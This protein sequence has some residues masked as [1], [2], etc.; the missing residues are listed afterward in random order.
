P[1]CLAIDSECLRQPSWARC[2]LPQVCRHACK[3]AVLRHDLQP[4]RWP[5]R[6]DQHCRGDSPCTND[7]VEAVVHAVDLKD[8]C[9]ATRTKHN[10]GTSCSTRVPGMRCAILWPHVYLCFDDQS[11]AS[12]F[13]QI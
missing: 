2:K 9:V 13:G 3:T 5:Q 6:S 10:I 12:A 11:A 4:E 7:Y 1:V 8:V